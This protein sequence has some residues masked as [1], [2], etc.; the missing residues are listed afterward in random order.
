MED[1]CFEKKLADFFLYV[2]GNGVDLPHVA[3]VAKHAFGEQMGPNMQ[4]SHAVW[5][6]AS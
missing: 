1:P 5:Q 4:K 3:H 2:C 6:S